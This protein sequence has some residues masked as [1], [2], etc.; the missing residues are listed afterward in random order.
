M[1]DK[2]IQKIR[3][4]EKDTLA[5]AEKYYGCI[6]VINSLKLTER[7]I[8]LVAFSAVKGSVSLINVREEF[9]KVYSTSS[10][11]INNIVSRLKKKGVLIKKN[12]KVIVTPAIGLNF[13]KDIVLE[14]NIVHED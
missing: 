2:V 6:A 5:I 3:K 11:T 4:S 14:I 8:Q 10:P 12:G 13:E 9:C 1:R 7:E